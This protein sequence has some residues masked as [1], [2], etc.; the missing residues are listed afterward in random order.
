MTRP[1]AAT[2][3]L[4]G[5]LLLAVPAQAGVRVEAREQ[6]V[7][8]LPT[9]ARAGSPRTLPA[10]R[11][12]F[13]FHLAGVHWR[14]RGYVSFR[15]QALSG[16]WSAW[17]PARPEAEDR[18]DLGREEARRR[19]GWKL[20]NP[21]W[22]GPSGR[23]QV[24]VTGAVTR[25]RAN[26][27]SSP[28]TGAPA[29]A[30]RM[31]AR[32]AVMARAQWGADE[33]LVRA[34]PSYAARLAFAVVHHT[35]GARPRTASESAAVVRGILA[36][37]VKS[38][39]WNDIGYNFLVDPFGQVFEGRAGGVSRNVVGAH[40]Q[41]FNTGSVGV[42]LLGTYQS[43]SITPAARAALV[44]L[45]SWRLDLAHV[46]PSSRLRWTSG[47]NPKWPAG[48]VVSLARVSGH[49]DVGSTSCPGGALYAELPALARAVAAYAGPKL[50]DPRVQGSPG[51]PVRFTARLS[52][53]RMW[54]VTVSDAV[55]TTV[56][57]GR[58]TGTAV[59]WTWDASGVSAADR[60]TYTIGAGTG[61]RP[62][63]GV[64]GPRS[65]LAVTRLA[66]APRLLTPNGDGTGERVR[67]S[68]TVSA[69]ATVSLRV[70]DERGTTVAT[71]ASARAV[72][73][74][75]TLY[76]WDGRKPDGSP[77]P[78]GRYSLL[79]EAARGS[80]R[81]TR[82]TSLVVDSTLAAL[83]VAPSAF[84]P[85]GDG[86][87]ETAS[88]RFRVTRA[89]EVRARV[90]AASRAVATLL[91]RTVLAPA[92]YA[93]RWDGAAG[94]G[95]APEGRYR[96]VVAATTE[97]GTRVLSAPLVLDTTAPEVTGL[98]ARRRAGGTLVRFRASEPVRVT[99]RFGA[100]VV[101][102]SV[103]AGLV[104]IWRPLGPN[105]VGVAAEDAAGNSSRPRR[106]RV[107][108]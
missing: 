90:F 106:A 11:A 41:G 10:L 35:A 24:R 20:G 87:R 44:R 25:V 14:G 50:F 51:G 36:Y 21:Y 69:A 26:F 18:P 82:E 56:A 99:L 40:A 58:G 102:R 108:D 92:V 68:V 63:R 88:V 95:A 86:R 13:A 100:T 9:L 78:D 53:A 31:P 70:R 97:L 8:A 93:L 89:A 3:A 83:T 105:F 34:A 79:A 94:P 62:A 101:R 42:A 7:P 85:N 98:S 75:T 19:S 6:A 60:L 33:S 22:V 66:V 46:D 30:T 96:V 49:R 103:P 12:P 73:A 5:A 28:V 72:S 74:G 39:G 64:L 37:H 57:S 17:R 47:G 32:P 107:R 1:R 55:G 80:E 67:V 84:S 77:V 16:R 15:T 54:S 61:V 48:T 2:A 23:L 43:S 59:D 27:V 38:N 4:A 65:A 71:L 45:L 81:G 52:E 104:S 91:P 29:P 76:G